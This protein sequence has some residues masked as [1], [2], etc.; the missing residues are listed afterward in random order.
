[1]KNFKI[2]I[3]I[4]FFISLFLKVEGDNILRIDSVNTQNFPKI[5]LTFN[6]VNPNIKGKEAMVLMEGGQS[7]NF[8]LKKTENKIGY[9]KRN[10]LILLEDMCDKTHPG[11]K[12]FF[13]N[14]LMNSL[15]N[16]IKNGDRINIAKFD[17]SRKGE[18]VLRLL[19]PEYTDNTKT[20]IKSVINLKSNNDIF[21]NQLSSDL[22][23]ALFD[24]INELVDKFPS[25]NKILILLSAGKNNKES[26][27]S[28]PDRAI[29]LA[30]TYR[31]PIYSVQY[32]MQGWEHNRL[33]PVVNATFG[34]EIIT[35]N[36][37]IA[38][39]SLNQFV[40]NSL[41]RISG[42]TYQISFETNVSKDGQ[43]H[44]FYLYINGIP[45]KIEFK[46]VKKTLLEYY[47][48][49]KIYS[50]PIT[51]F[52]FLLVV[53]LFLLIIKSNKKRRKLKT[54]LQYFENSTENTK[55]IVKKQQEQLEILN[56]NN[57]EQKE[58]QEYKKNLNEMHRSGGQP[59]IIITGN[60]EKIVYS[61]KKPIV[62]VGRDASN[63]LVL[64]DKMVS[65][66]HAIIFFSGNEY[67]I[68]DLNSK[69]GI[70]INGKQINKEK[71]KKGD[72]IE[73]GKKKL[74]FL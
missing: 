25:N 2:L 71:I 35:N 69:N 41:K 30:K 58:I 5:V 60:S 39:D 29:N 73:I 23:F 28:T 20:L 6:V 53:F 70:Y 43:Y 3:F 44:F 48:E 47:T 67:F 14:V 52:V 24:G 46:V 38:I 49:N 64:N 22:Y 40:N 37:K 16:F 54:K 65:R 11:Q 59:R 34:E 45:N 55:K 62:K 50:I 66:K 33:T 8:S 56:K 7:V 51:I 10:I 63:D 19:L 4:L 42:Q 61:M 57:H 74:M 21:Y 72:L 15:K 32:R 9:T 68:K 36:I 17:R 12:D 13:Q 1:M 18:P 31:I 27:E 26:S